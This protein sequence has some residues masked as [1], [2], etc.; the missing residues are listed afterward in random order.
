M[1]FTLNLYRNNSEKIALDKSLTLIAYYNGVLKA[2]TSIITPTIL[3]EC[4]LNDVALANYAYIPTFQRYYFIT[5]ITSVRKSLVQFDMHCDVLAS[6]KT[7][8]RNNEAVI[9]RQESQYNLYTDDKQMRYYAKPRVTVK[10]FPHGFTGFTP[11]LSMSGSETE[12]C[13]T[14]WSITSYENSNQSLHTTVAG[15]VGFEFSSFSQTT[16]TTNIYY[17]GTKYFQTAWTE[18]GTYMRS[19]KGLN[20]DAPWVT[21]YLGEGETHLY[22]PECDSILVWRNNTGYDTLLQEALAIYA[23]SDPDNPNNLVKYNL[24]N[25]TSRSSA[26][27]VELPNPTKIIRLEWAEAGAQ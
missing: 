20:P 3:V 13:S 8:I 10:E 6:F 12:D 5:N 11:V 2:E 24:L 23:N 4:D 16:L 7:Q 22:T 27:E 26:L 25:Y 17:V 9:K 15:G 1:S 19:K 18:D 14:L 21:R